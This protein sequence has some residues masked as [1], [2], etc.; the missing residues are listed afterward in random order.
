M[1]SPLIVF[2]I[3][4]ISFQRHLA[5]PSTI[6]IRYSFERP[7]RCIC[8]RRRRAPVSSHHSKSAMASRLRWRS[9]ASFSMVN[10]LARAH[11]TAVRAS[12][13]WIRWYNRTCYS[14]ALQWSRS[15][16]DCHHMTC[17]HSCADGFSSFQLVSVGSRLLAGWS[18]IISPYAL[19][20][21]IAPPSCFQSASILPSVICAASLLIP[22]YLMR[23]ESWMFGKHTHKTTSVCEFGPSAVG[24]ISSNCYVV[25]IDSSVCW[26]FDSR[27]A[28]VCWGDL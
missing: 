12:N 26:C 3:V 15:H 14:C 10:L 19:A 7:H 2:G 17:F 24:C 20:V 25:M 21:M 8:P 18:L 6:F 27:R 28:R 23:C 1:S 11:D 22:T 16:S 13:H 4:T 9:A 5:S